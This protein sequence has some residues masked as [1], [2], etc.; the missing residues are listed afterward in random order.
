[1]DINNKLSHLKHILP[2]EINYMIRRA[3]QIIKQKTPEFEKRAINASK[4][5]FFLD[6]PAYANLGDQAIAYAME[7]FMATRFP[8]YEQFEIQED[9]LPHY[10]DWLMKNICPDDLICLT[11]GGNMG[12]MYQS[13]EATRRYVMKKFKDSHIIVFPQTFDYGR[14]YYGMKELKRS[15][16]VYNAC[17]NLVIAARDKESY[18]RMKESYS[19]ANVVYSPDIVLSLD[20]SNLN[21][22]NK[23]G[24]GICLRE[25]EE[26]AVDKNTKGAI[27]REYP[28]ARELTTIDNSGERIIGKKREE[29]IF[30]VIDDFSS[31]EMVITDRLHGTIF[32]YI[33]NTPCIALPN[34][35]GK[36]ERLCNL[37]S[38]YGNV[39]FMK[40]FSP[41]TNNSDK[42]NRMLSAEFEDL[43][44]AIKD[45]IQ[46]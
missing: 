41:I 2:M 16:K 27:K 46:S 20:Y 15:K 6:T 39:N 37:L 9:M 7:K 32:S 44:N 12:V 1:M 31:C 38:N 26:S 29:K 36:V 18:K 23:V 21:K 25:D 22:N 24:T 35:N 8:E 28:S 4:R 10:T 3:K 13:Y 40:T 17:S 11:G 30:E 33:T 19:S 42:N 5:I 45:Q 14:S 43:E 34:S